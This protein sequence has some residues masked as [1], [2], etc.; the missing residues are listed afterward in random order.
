METADHDDHADPPS[1][2]LEVAERVV[3]RW[4]ARCVTD[5]ARLAG[6]D[7]AAHAAKID[8][9]VAAETERLL[10]DLRALLAADVDEQRTNPLSLFRRATAGPTEVLRSLGVPPVHRDRFAT[11][12]F[13]DDLYAL[14]PATWA[15]VDPALHEPGIA[16]GA[17]KA[18]TV[19]RR[20]RQQD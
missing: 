20:R 12:Q 6:V 4:L 17:W 5:R 9:I 11:E 18:L 14:T 15:D 2:L 3:P 16:W 8:A 10:A 19:L 7:I 13:P 1:E